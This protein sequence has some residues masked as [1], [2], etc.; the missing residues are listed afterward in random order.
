MLAACGLL[1]R[2]PQEVVLVGGRGDP[3][4]AA[5]AR[6]L[7]ARFAPNRVVLLVDSAETR[8]ELAAGIPAIES[9]RKI[10]GRASAYVCRGY[11][12]QLPVFEP[13]KLAALIQ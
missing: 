12:C 2:E 13:E 6:T 1:L 3:D 11:A 10:G 4:T 5:L 7:H 9:M 8:S